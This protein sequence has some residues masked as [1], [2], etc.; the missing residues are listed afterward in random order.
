ME[1]EGKGKREGVRATISKQYFL[2][3]I[4]FFQAGGD[5]ESLVDLLADNYTGTAQSANLL[6]NWL[7]FTGE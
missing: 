1:R 2:S 3:I 5:S 4:R 6:A 7:I